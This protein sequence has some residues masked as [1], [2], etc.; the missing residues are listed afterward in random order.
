MPPLP[1][2]ADAAAASGADVAL[3][4]SLEAA[5]MAKEGHSPAPPRMQ[6]LFT[7]AL[8]E[9]IRKALA[10]TGGD[11]AFQALVLQAQNAQVDEHVR[12]AAQLAAD[13]RAIRAATDAIAHPG[14]LRDLPAGAMRDALARLHRLAAAGSWTELASAIERLLGQDLCAEQR[15]Q[16][17]LGA[18]LSDPALQRL[19]RGSALLRHEAVQRYGALQEQRG[20]LAGSD[21]AAASG[22]ASARLGELAEHTTAQAFLEI[23]ETLNRRAGASAAYRVLR[24]LRPPPGFPGEA[25]KAKDEWDAAIVRSDAGGAADILLLAEIKASPAA[26]TSDFPRLLR[27]L[28]RLAHASADRSYAFASA[29]G[30]AC[31][32]G[33]SLRRLDPHGR[34]LPPQVIYCCSAL[35]EAQP[36]VLSAASKA[37]LLAEPASLA[38]AHQ[39]ARGEAAPHAHLAPVWDALTTAPR[40]RS[41]LHQYQSAQALRA[42][43]LHPLDLLSAI[44]AW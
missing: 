34:S 38:F 31:I 43:M 7:R 17:L 18:I 44:A 27:G 28:R 9:L 19:A 3:A 14:K 29:D 37:V 30:E 24:S 40:L 1:A 11:P 21:A 15:L 36:P 39:L 6:E 26:A 32:L 13:R 12:L 2:D 5:R 42:A 10:P 16:T 22:R 4:F 41:A 35:P 20:P 33:A 23:A 25:N 8:A